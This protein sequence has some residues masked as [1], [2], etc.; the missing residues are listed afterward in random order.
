MFQDVRGGVSCPHG[1]TDFMHT[2]ED[3][4][5]RAVVSFSMWLAV[6][7]GGSPRERT[8]YPLA[9]LSPGMHTQGPGRQVQ[10]ARSAGGTHAAGAEVPPVAQGEV[11]SLLTVPSVTGL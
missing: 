2:L 3:R 7:E 4:E 10:A 9:S 8:L 5:S 1:D 11:V 6:G